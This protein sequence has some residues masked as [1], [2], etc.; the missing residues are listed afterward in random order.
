M[1]MTDG[2]FYL[3]KLPIRVISDVRVVSATSSDSI[4]LRECWVEFK[5]LTPRQ[6]AKLEEFI[7]NHTVGEA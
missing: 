7:E 2:D 6:R 1:F 3:G 4:T 5:D